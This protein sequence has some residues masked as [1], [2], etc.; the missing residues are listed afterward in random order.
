M[1]T[2]C[3]R[4]AWRFRNS[5]RAGRRARRRLPLALLL[6][7]AAL[8]PGM[9][10]AQTTAATAPPA[11]PA[12]VA[13]RVESQAIPRV[14]AEDLLLLARREQ[15]A[16]ALPDLLQRLALEW[17]L[18]EDARRQV[19]DA[20]LFTARRVAFEPAMMVERQWQ[21][22]AWQRWPEALPAA[23]D[24]WQRQARL[25]SPDE[26]AA[27]QR[28]RQ[29][30]ARRSLS[31]ISAEAVLPAGAAGLVLLRWCEPGACRV[32][33][34]V[35]LA[36]VWPQLNV[37]G[38]TQILA[39]DRDFARQQALRWLQDRFT[40]TWAAAPSRWGVEGAQALEALLWA[41]VRWQALLRWEGLDGDGHGAAPG[42]VSGTVP[43]SASPAPV[44]DAEIEQY[45]REHPESFRRISRLEGWR[46][47][48]DDET[49]REAVTP[50]LRRH[51]DLAALVAQQVPGLSVQAVQ[52]TDA[53]S[54]VGAGDAAGTPPFAGARQA[55]DAWSLSL[56]AATPVGPPSAALR[57]PGVA[58]RGWE[59]VQVRHREERLQPLD[60][61]TVRYGATQA[62]MQQRREAAWR[63]RQEQLLARAALQW[64]PDLAAPTVSPLVGQATELGG[65]RH[66]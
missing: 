64:A 46:A 62:L 22:M 63:D 27:W 53:P 66:D 18:G 17:L 28:L 38:R 29:P 32:P 54:G 4:T 9:A 3:T 42:V 14:L 19:G 34:A 61:E 55:L 52:W 43:G 49:C 2:A 6:S 37:Q 20:Q 31:A 15:P 48:C 44:T 40:R 65:H 36:E 5:W 47:R 12:A 16:L 41:R 60:S 8:Q 58:A 51:P 39:G 59:W 23:W 50:L 7:C 13:L 45:W 26:T 21:A 10:S 35:T 11:L 24:G 30:P 25:T 33:S 57:H 1:I 56:M